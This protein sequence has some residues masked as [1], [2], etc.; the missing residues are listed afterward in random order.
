MIN[1]AKEYLA[2][3]KSGDEIVS[4]KVRE[5]YQR[6]VNWMNHPPENFPFYFD[7]KEGLRHIEFIEKFCKHSKGKFAG[8]PVILE[9]FQKA[10]IQTVFGWRYKDT[11]LRRFHEVGDIR[12]RKCGKSTETAAVA[13]D[14]SV[15]DGEGGPEI[16]C[17]A[18]KKDQ[19]DLIYSE[20]VNMRTQ[21]PEL[22]AISKKRQSDIY[23][24]F[25]MGKIKCLASDT[26]TMD[27]LNPSFFSQDEFHAAKTS[28]LYDVMIQGQSMRDNPLAWLIS[29]NGFEREGFFD[30]KYN[31]YSQIALWSPGFEDYHTFPLIY[32]LDDRGTWEDPAHWPEANPGLGK[33]KKIETLRENVEK[34]KRD[35]SFLPTLLA[36]DFNLSTTKYTSWLRFEEAFND[37]KIDMDYISH[38]YALGGCDLSSVYDL[39][40]A[41]L[42]IRKP[43]DNRIYMLQHYFVPQKRIDEIEI[44][45]SRE[46]PYKLWADQGWITICEGASVNYHQVTEWFVHMVK[47]YDIRP[48]WVFYDRALA[49]YWQEDMEAYSFDMQKIPQGPITWTY[50]MKTMYA[51]FKEH[52]IVY[53]NNP[54]TRWCLLNTAKKSTNESGIESIQPVKVQAKK[55]IDGTVSMLNAFTGYINHFE[56]YMAYLR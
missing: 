24:P 43:D 37:A 45:D 41:T 14:V 7:E 47:D 36:K 11:G 28:A 4:T 56:E 2:S 25:N 50:P 48:L 53:D 30:S 34:A 31:Y 15:N 21:S 29:T 16:Y 1:Y 6:E 8:Q 22:K 27:G 26:S 51:A 55:R 18:N 54:V 46:A 39:T 40:C 49:G 35:P 19:A 38:S 42:L 10:K 3:I 9:P 33:I 52:L 17:T 12:A 20:C 44:S 23:I 32:E 5:V 13:W